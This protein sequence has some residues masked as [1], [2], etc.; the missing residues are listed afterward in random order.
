MRKRIVFQGFA[1]SVDFYVSFKSY[2]KFKDIQS[3]VLVIK[4]SNRRESAV[5]R[6]GDRKQEDQRIWN[7]SE[8]LKACWL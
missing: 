7:N 8:A 3:S 5:T 1:I 4:R 2:G 6:E